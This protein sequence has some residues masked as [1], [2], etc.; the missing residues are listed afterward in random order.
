MSVGVIHLRVKKAI[1]AFLHGIHSICLPTCDCFISQ[2]H[3]NDLLFMF[4]GV[5]FKAL[6]TT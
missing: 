6:T 3:T 4:S 2:P 1:F 5:S